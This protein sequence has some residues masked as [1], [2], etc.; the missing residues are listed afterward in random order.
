[1]VLILG[2]ERSAKHFLCALIMLEGKNAL[3]LGCAL[4]GAMGLPL[5]LLPP[6][7]RSIYSRLWSSFFFLNAQLGLW[8]REALGVRSSWSGQLRLYWWAA[9]IWFNEGPSAQP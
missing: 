6:V 2:G 4:L 1:V 3:V 5:P 9:L 8:S 7:P